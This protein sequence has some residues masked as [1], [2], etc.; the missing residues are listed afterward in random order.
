MQTYTVALGDRAYPIYIGSNLLTNA[1]LIIPHLAQKRVALITNEVVAPLYLSS[2][3]GTLESAGVKVVP[4]ILPDGEQ[5]KTWETLNKVYDQMLTARCERGTTIVALGG[6]VVGDISGFA[7]AT[8]Q[9][10]IPFIQIPTTLLAQVDSSI[11]GKTA[12]NHPLG[13]NMIGAFYQPKAVIS[14]MGTLL[15]LPDREL[16]AGLAEII[17]HGLIR[18]AEFFSWLETNI[19]RILARDMDALTHAVLRSCEIKGA[20]VVNDER[21]LGE[22]ALLNFGHTFGH[23]IENG[24]GYGTWLHGE[25]I[26]AGMVLASDLSMRLGML[27]SPEPTR[28]RKLLLRAGLPV[29]VSG[30]SRDKMRE[31][32]SLDKKAKDGKLRFILLERVGSAVVRADVSSKT[33]DQTLELVA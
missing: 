11:G 29:E 9:R 26:A 23:A 10:G 30:L 20:V 22:R 28:I 33:L 17:K 14:D 13:K 25:A 31:L 19:D 18:D 16:K 2:L 1:D 4:I 24:M 8:Y 15:S 21:E 6:G 5:H 32:M 27:K 3:R 7:A 12:V